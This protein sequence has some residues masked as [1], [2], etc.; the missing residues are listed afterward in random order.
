MYAKIITTVVLTACAANT[1]REILTTNTVKGEKN[2]ILKHG[3]KCATLGILASAAISCA[4]SIFDK[5]K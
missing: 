2:A 5:T 3:I 4:A 1:A